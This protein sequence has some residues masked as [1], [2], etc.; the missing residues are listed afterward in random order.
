MMKFSKGNQSDFYNGLKP[1]IDEYFES[2]NASRFGNWFLFLKG[3]ILLMIFLLAYLSIFI[4]NRTFA[5]LV[6][7]YM[8]IGVT[9]VMIVFN[10]VHDASHKAVSK[11]KWINRSICF[12]GDLLGINTHIWNIRHNIQHH[13]FTNILGGDLIIESIPLIRLSPHQP[14]KGFHKYQLLY[15]PFLYLFYSFYWMFVIDFKLFFKKEICNLYNIKHPFKEWCILFAT[16][17][18]YLFYMIYL[19]W[20]FTSVG[21]PGVLGYFFLM[22]FIAGLLLSIVAVMGHFV[23]GPSFPEPR[24][25][26][27]E[28]SWSEHE[29][30]ATIDFA[31]GSHVVNWITGGLNTHIAH[32]LFPSICHVHYFDL[33]KIIKGYCEANHYA[34]KNET[35][36]GGL[37]SHVSY[38]KKLSSP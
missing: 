1:L 5:G 34:Y 15:A 13:T 8:I 21:L 12:I 36:I 32:H 10:L 27:I 4:E 25:G 22:H 18:F 31:P 11:Y 30:E 3:V 23:E 29:L 17:L 7:S 20:A 16:K 38:L 9:G 6:C 37:I 2:R 19:P 28:K 24:E 26:V 33:T 35:L 14:Y